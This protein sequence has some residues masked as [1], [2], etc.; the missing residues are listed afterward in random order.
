MTM[1]F[2]LALF[3]LLDDGRGFLFGEET[4]VYHLFQ[5]LQL[6]LQLKL[7][8]FRHGGGSVSPT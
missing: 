4:A 1:D 8:A 6:S 3:S 5:L 7:D 2:V